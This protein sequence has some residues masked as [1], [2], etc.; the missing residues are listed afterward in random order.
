MVQE[1]LRR[2]PAIGRCL[3]QAPHDHASECRRHRRPVQR[4][5]LWYPRDLRGEHLL[6]R[7]AGE[8]RTAR[9]HL[10]AEDAYRVQVTAVVGVGIGRDLFRRHVRGCAERHTGRGETGRPGRGAD[11]L[12]DSKVRHQGVMAREQHVVGL[13]V[14]MDDAVRVGVGQGIHHIAQHPHHLGHRQFPAA[15]ELGAQRL[16]LDEGHGVVGEIL[17]GS[18]GKQRDDVRVLQRSGELDF[19]NEPIPVDTG[20]QVRRQD[21][22]YHT[23]PQGCVRCGKDATHPP[24]AQ[25]LVEAVGRAHGGLET[26]AKVGHGTNIDLRGCTSDWFGLTPAGRPRAITEKTRRRAGVLYRGIRA[27]TCG[28]SGSPQAA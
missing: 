28:P 6:G 4:D 10:G 12:R 17:L 8:R 26:L 23:A 25:F 21:F 1:L 24:A 20:R 9:Q 18:G 27:E 3:F 19:P 2:L 5:P 15:A 22:E 11:R 7:R 14:A 16:A 13:A